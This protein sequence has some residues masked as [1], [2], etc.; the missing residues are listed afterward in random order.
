[1]KNIKYKFGFVVLHYKN[2]EDTIE[3]VDSLVYKVN[4]NKLIFIVDNFSNDGTKELLENKYKENKNI[5]IISN[6][7][8]L[9]FAKGNNIG[10]KVAKEKGCD[11]V[12]LINNDTIIKQDDFILKCIENWYEY[13]YSIG[14]PRIISTIDGFDQNPYML[15]S[16]F[17]KSRKDAVRMYVVGLAKYVFI[18]L[19]FKEWWNK[20]GTR[21]NI[22]ENLEKR[23][24]NS[25]NNDF[26]LNGA[27]II[28][29]PTFFEKYNKLCDLTFMYEE[30]TIL[31]FLSKQLNI[32]NMY[33]PNLEIYHKEQSSTKKSFGSERKKLLFGYR[34]DFNSRKKLLKI[35][36]K[37]NDK[38]FL[39]GLI[40]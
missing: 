36:F 35:V 31:Y 38:E 7:S 20:E 8:N 4:Y 30:E 25:E 13:N 6:T 29:S 11:F 16:H 5:F 28:L 17:V 26:L 27:C 21:E 40:K 33:L 9:G 23:L 1:M 18:R 15:H 2:I 34:E 37:K 3:C 19:G 32:K 39:E 10:I 14:G 12:C 22:T 24:L